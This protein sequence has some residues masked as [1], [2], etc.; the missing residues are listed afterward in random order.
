ME[1]LKN[2]IEKTPDKLITLA[3]FKDNPFEPSLPLEQ[4]LRSKYLERG[5]EALKSD[6]VQVVPI[7]ESEI[8][9]DATG[10]PTEGDTRKILLELDHHYAESM[11][12]NAD[13]LTSDRM[14]AGIQSVFRYG[15]R[16]CDRKGQFPRPLGLCQTCI[17]Q[18]GPYHG[19]EKWATFV[20]SQ[21][22]DPVRWGGGGG[23]HTEKRAH[24]QDSGSEDDQTKVQVTET[25]LGLRTPTSFIVLSPV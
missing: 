9:K 10:H 13:Y 19:A 16:T 5:L 24:E 4:T 6:K 11:L 25:H 18:I 8:G 22:P 14:Y 15:C 21:S 1:K 23:G 12:L 3:Y 2:E 7:P 20:Q 17:E